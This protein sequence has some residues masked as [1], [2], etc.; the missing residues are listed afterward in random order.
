M[1][2][3]DDG[4]VPTIDPYHYTPVEGV[5]ATQP[6][7]M[8][9]GSQ[10]MAQAYPASV[11][12]PS[13]SGRGGVSRATSSA[14]SAGYAGYGAGAAG[15]AG[16]GAGAGGLNFPSP[17]PSGQPG[18]PPMSPPPG[19]TAAMSPKQLEAYQEQQRF[20]IANP[21]AASAPG[22]SGVTVHEDGGVFEEPTQGSEI[23]P[24]YDSIRR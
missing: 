10:Q 20:R 18:S 1:D 19:A 6:S 22:P 14:T 9:H 16:V 8:S 17:H 15:L 23:P 7:Q 21:S 12:N 13:D 2:L 5:A 24:T 3:A 4:G 11:S